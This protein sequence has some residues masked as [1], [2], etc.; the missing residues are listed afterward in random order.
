MRYA[1]TGTP[2]AER[3]GRLRGVVDL[4]AGRYPAFVFGAGVGRHLPVFHFHETTAAALEP[5]FQYLVENGYRTVT[6]DAV[7]TLVRDGVH[8]GDRTV[9]LAF[10]D[11][12]ASLWLVVAPLLAKYD[13]QAVTYAIPARMN[14]ADRPRPNADVSPADA[15]AADEAPHPFVTWPELRALAL[16]GRVDVQSHT[17]SHSMMFVGDAVVGSVDETF[18]TEPRLNHPRLNTGNPPEFLEADRVGFPLFAR[19]SR[20]SD[21]RRFLPDLEACARAEAF[22]A[23]SKGSGGLVARVEG[24]W[25]TEADQAAAIE[26]ELVAARDT[27]EARLGMTVRHMCLPWGVSGD[28]TRRALERLGFASAFANRWSGRLAVAAGD[29]PFFL[30]RLHSRYVFALPG[31][32]RRSF[33]MLA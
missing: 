26:Y 2:F 29:D 28:R 30:K 7:S 23:G 12:W 3:G 8:P 19:R 21:G 22:A 11:A 18:A 15:A 17:W 32:G 20:M 16:S 5:V 27:L 6:S 9:M 10:D 25:E 14:D 4:V 1:A 31:R 33:T 24:S 13:L